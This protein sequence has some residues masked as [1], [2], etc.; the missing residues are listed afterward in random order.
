MIEFKSISKIYP[1]K[2]NFM[3]KVKKYHYALHDVSLKIQPGLVT[4]IVGESGSGKSTLARVFTGLVK[5]DEGAFHWND[6]DSS[7]MERKEWNAFRRKVQMVFQDPYGSL[8]PRLKVEAILEEPFKIHSR[9]PGKISKE[10]RAHKIRKVAASVGIPEDSLQKYPHEFSGGQRQRIGIARALL[11]DPEVL[12]LDEPVSALDVSIQAQILNLLIDLKE[13]M[14]LTYMF[15]AHDLGV[16]SY[17][18]D[19]IAVIYYG[20]IM[21]YGSTKDIFTSPKHPYTKV[22][23]DAMPDIG[24]KMTPREETTMAAPPESLT[25]GCPFYARCTE[26]LEVCRTQFPE[27][28]GDDN[29]FYCCHNPLGRKKKS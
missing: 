29:A 5:P 24:K 3:G 8:N 16:V 19:Q 7:V 2:K 4:G 17:I 26:R 22:L 18:S 25:A 15:I 1:V 13:K 14:E 28:T 9:G 10:E 20:R 11:L 21:E 12:V 23:L 27:K 6:F